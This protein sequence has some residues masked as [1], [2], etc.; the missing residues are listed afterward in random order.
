MVAARLTLRPA[1]APAA[2]AAPPRRS[3]VMLLWFLANAAIGVWNIAQ[4]GA[5]AFQ[6]LSPH[7]MYY[8]WSVRIILSFGFD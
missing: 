8:Y 5:G 7:Y 1:A 3:P 6:A 2:A 4:H